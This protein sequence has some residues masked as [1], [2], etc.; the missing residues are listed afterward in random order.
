MLEKLKDLSQ[1]QKVV[2]GS[3]L[4]AILLIAIIIVP[5]LAANKEKVEAQI[6]PIEVDLTLEYKEE[7]E[8]Q[9]TFE[10]GPELEITVNVEDIVPQIDTALIGRTNHEVNM[11]S[12]DLKLTVMIED[13]REL[14]LAGETEFTV[15]FGSSE[16]E[17]EEM[18]IESITPEEVEAGDE[19][20]FA[21]EYPEEFDLNEEG[22][23]DLTLA[24]KFVDN[25]DNK[26]TKELTVIVEDS[27]ELVLEGKTQYT[28]DVGLSN[29]N[30][31]KMVLQNFTFEENDELEFDFKYPEGFD[32]DKEGE[33]ALNLVASFANNSNNKTTEELTVIAEKEEP[34]VEQPVAQKPADNSGGSSDK[35]KAEVKPEPKPEPKPQP[36]PEPEPVVD[37]PVPPG[38]PSGAKF[39][40]SATTEKWHEFTYKRDL[41]GGGTISEVYVSINS[42]GFLRV[43]M[44][45][46]DDKGLRTLAR[47]TPGADGIHHIFFGERAEYTPSDTSMHM[48]IG[49]AF[50][51]A[52]GF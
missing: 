28:V 29:E 36:K 10:I 27:R 47:Y 18:V 26:T 12:L 11:E 52:Y 45:S 31:E 1:K 24:A 35:P 34:I 32:L 41:P 17:F 2:I 39:T 23:Y 8:E 3:L 38:I 6:E 48:E 43:T 51:E 40:Y 20:E 4:I 49:R 15:E 7:L 46:E 44:Q 50:A 33:Y 19:L 25:H 9:Y 5:L 37:F 42:D 22:E 14:I 13:T 16:E 21:F 30:F